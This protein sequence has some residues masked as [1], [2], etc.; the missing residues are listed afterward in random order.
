M[1]NDVNTSI[2]QQQKRNVNKV[3][4]KSCKIQ[5]R[6][7]RKSTQEKNIIKQNDGVQPCKLQMYQ[8][9]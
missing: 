6:N 4:H 3:R 9:A 1:K 2:Q 5:K 8:S 7:I